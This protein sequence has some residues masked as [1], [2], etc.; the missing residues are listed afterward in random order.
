MTLDERQASGNWLWGWGRPGPICSVSI[1]AIGTK[2]GAKSLGSSYV[3]HIPSPGVQ[4]LLLA[5]FHV[6]HYISSHT[7]TTLIPPDP[8]RGVSS[9]V[10][11]AWPDPP[12]P[13]HSSCL[14]CSRPQTTQQTEGAPAP[15]RPRISNTL[16]GSL[17]GC[18]GATLTPPVF[19]S[20]H[21]LT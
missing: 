8:V 3:C 16:D 21:G 7:A 4:E 13:K 10:D 11:G 2:C 6:P 14:L 1:Q 5:S 12:A 9:H 20:H 17:C 15:P 18:P 19:I